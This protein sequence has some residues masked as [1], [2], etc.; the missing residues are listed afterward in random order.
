MSSMHVEPTYVWAAYAHAV[1]VL[2]RA[3]SVCLYQGQ[4]A[5]QQLSRACPQPQSGR[6]MEI[7]EIRG[8]KFGVG[9]VGVPDH[10]GQASW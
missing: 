4:R 3:V 10:L 6:V 2:K 9:C 7:A 1:S 5:R 8:E